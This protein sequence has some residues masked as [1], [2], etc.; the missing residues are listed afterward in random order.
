MITIVDTGTSNLNSIVN[1]FRR[2]G[3]CTQVINNPDELFGC[4]RLLMPGVGSFD[5]NMKA[6]KLGG[7]IEPLS[8]VVI[9]RGVPILGICA[10]MQIMTQFSEEGD[11]P[12]LG[13]IEGSVK[14]FRHVNAEI[15]RI[16]HMGWNRV[17]RVGGPELGIDWHDTQRYYFVHSYHVACNNIDDVW[18]VADY[19]Y[20][21][22]AAFAKRNIFG[23]QFHPEKSHKYG[24][25][26]L[27]GYNNHHDS[28]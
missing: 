23:T 26:I 27:T 20:N 17:E 3:I 7:W 6:L 13:W 12:G 21:F 9:N 5:A 19:G 11:E 2:L 14:K 15:Y 22:V 28:N 1:M 16:P 4:K 10:G 24:M 25:S 18:L 8:E